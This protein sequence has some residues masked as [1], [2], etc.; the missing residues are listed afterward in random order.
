M[1]FFILALNP[2][3]ESQFFMLSEIVFHCV[4]ALTEKAA[5]PN[6][7]RRKGTVQLCAEAILVDRWEFFKS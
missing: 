6:A 5:C 2:P 4:T 1:F 3:S 7:E